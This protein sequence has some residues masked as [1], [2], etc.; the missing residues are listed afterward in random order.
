MQKHCFILEMATVGVILY[1][2]AA[3]VLIVIVKPHKNEI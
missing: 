3:V 1:F 2:H